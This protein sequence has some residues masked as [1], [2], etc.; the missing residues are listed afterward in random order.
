MLYGDYDQEMQKYDAFCYEYYCRLRQNNAALYRALYENW[1]SA[2]NFYPAHYGWI[3]DMNFSSKFSDSERSSLPI[4]QSNEEWQKSN[5]YSTA[6]G[7]E[8]NERPEIDF[9]YY[10]SYFY[11][12]YDAMRRINPTM[13][14]ILYAK[15]CA[16]HH[17]PVNEAYRS[18]IPHNITA[19]ES[20]HLARERL[21]KDFITAHCDT[22]GSEI[23]TSD[24]SSSPETKEMEHLDRGL[25]E[26][27]CQVTSGSG[28][29]GNDRDITSEAQLHGGFAADRVLPKFYEP[30]D[31]NSRQETKVI[32][33]EQLQ[34][35]C[36]A[37]N[38]SLNKTD[39]PS[40]KEQGKSW[41]NMFLNKMGF[42]KTE[43]HL[44]DDDCP[45]IVWDNDR[46]QWIDTT[47]NENSYSGG[48]LLPPKSS[49]V[50]PCGANNVYRLKKSRDVRSKYVDVLQTSNNFQM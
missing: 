10:D 30:G 46:K 44:P 4:V 27:Y 48:L 24:S 31:T 8:N 33:S 5:D 43:A 49:G 38:K 20:S 17:L 41:I 34:T 25:V 45:T 32:S 37:V 15:W 14:A 16:S 26:E 3:R 22:D 42:S 39:D 18:Q 11:G 36:A 47:T 19:R 2:N 29:Q 40:E 23:L 28:H 13:Y 1:Y 35:S 6:T 50:G 21:P 12:F 7:M 9:Q